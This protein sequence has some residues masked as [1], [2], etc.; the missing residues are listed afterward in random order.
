MTMLFILRNVSKLTD[1]YHSSGSAVVIA[2]DLARAK[3]LLKQVSYDVEDDD[4][5]KHPQVTDEEWG[6]AL[7]YVLSED[8]DEEVFIF[9][10]SGCC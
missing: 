6:S 8:K 9:P 7:F 2:K 3:E 1:S 10:D 5:R 4:D